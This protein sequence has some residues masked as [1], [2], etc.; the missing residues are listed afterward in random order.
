[1]A[2]LTPID[3]ADAGA[4]VSAYGLGTLRGWEGIAGGSVNSNFAVATDRGRFFLR[5]YEEQDREGA[6][7]ETAMLVRLSAAGVATPAPLPT[8][9]GSRVW[10]LRGKP[11]AVFPWRDG[12]MR[13]QAGVTADDARRVGEALARM[14]V[15]GGSEAAPESRFGIGPLQRRIDRI[16]ASGHPVFAPLA[17]ALRGWLEETDG[18]RD[19]SL[20]HGLI[21]GDLFRDNVLWAPSGEIAALLDFESA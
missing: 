20:P 19:R 2:V 4:L 18:A 16:E 3:D 14:H 12:T 8:A 17:P 5:L 15:A 6:E 21:H 1:M 7:R 13:C 11:A 10:E 9:Q